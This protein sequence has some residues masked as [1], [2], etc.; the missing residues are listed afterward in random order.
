M[1]YCLF[2]ARLHA[3]HDPRPRLTKWENKGMFCRPHNLL[4]FLLG[5]PAVMVPGQDRREPTG[6]PHLSAAGLR[7]HDSPVNFGGTGSNA[8]SR[9][10]IL[11]GLFLVHERILPIVIYTGQA[12]LS[13]ERLVR[14]VWSDNPIMGTTVDPAGKVFY[15]G[16]EWAVSTENTTPKLV[17]T[18]LIPAHPTTSPPYAS[19]NIIAPHLNHILE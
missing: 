11:A 2:L 9:I 4:P 3:Q 12:F 19:L 16:T 18:Y 8:R 13:P 17:K 6:Y 1:T 14:C 15:Q 5:Q 7:C 10:D